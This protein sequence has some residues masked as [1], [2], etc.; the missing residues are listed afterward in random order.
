MSGE[1][2]SP[3]TP[4][5]LSFCAGQGRSCRRQG[6]HPE[7]QDLG[8]RGH[9]SG[10]PGPLRHP[11]PGR[12]P[13]TLILFFTHMHAGAHTVPVEK[14]SPSPTRWQQTAA[15]DLCPLPASAGP[16]GCRRLGGPRPHAPGGNPSVLGRDRA[17]QSY[18]GRM[19]RNLAPEGTAECTPG[20]VS[21]SSTLSPLCLPQPWDLPG[22][23]PMCPNSTKKQ[24]S[25]A[26]EQEALLRSWRRIPEEGAAI[27]AAP[28][29]G[30]EA[31][32]GSQ[33]P[34]AVGRSE[35]QAARGGRPHRHAGGRRCPGRTDCLQG[36]PPLTLCKPVAHRASGCTT[37]PGATK[38]K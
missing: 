6:P 11:M 35:R 12:D 14:V 31:K 24:I 30:G 29:G 15:T 20:P 1:A 19:G 26:R 9:A 8:R 2:E 36:G 21:G 10:A 33:T 37:H 22:S 13:H 27:S 3:R 34:E 38:R 7:P 32:R 4:S 5:L 23:I 17:G 28:G 16:W 18:Y 25:E